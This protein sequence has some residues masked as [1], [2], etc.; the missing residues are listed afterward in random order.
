MHIQTMTAGALDTSCSSPERGQV[1][2]TSERLIILSRL[3]LF[4][5]ILV[6]S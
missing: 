5:V 4:D 2:G 3:P 1:K 6:V